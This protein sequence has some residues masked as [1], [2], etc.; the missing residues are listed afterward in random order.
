[1]RSQLIMLN[2]KFQAAC[3][4]VHSIAFPATVS[5]PTPCATVGCSKPA[6]RAP[7]AGS[8]VQWWSLSCSEVVWCGCICHKVSLIQQHSK[9]LVPPD[10][11]HPRACFAQ[12]MLCLAALALALWLAQLLLCSSHPG[13]ETKHLRLPI[14]NACIQLLCLQITSS[15]MA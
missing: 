5:R 6:N 7:F 12:C 14:T 15:L 11:P 13:S 4:T 8:T 9:V 10:L 3:I 1:M 2:S